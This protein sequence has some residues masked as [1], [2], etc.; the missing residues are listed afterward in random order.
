M[1][2][3]CSL[4]TLA[5]RSTGFTSIA[6]IVVLS[7]KALTK[8]SHHGVGLASLLVAAGD[9]EAKRNCVMVFPRVRMLCSIWFALWRHDEKKRMG[10]ASFSRP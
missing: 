10:R 5:I 7:A 1:L 2:V 3:V 4:G 9:L 8:S 6:T